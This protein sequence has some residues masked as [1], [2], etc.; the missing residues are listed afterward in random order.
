MICEESQSPKKCGG[1]LRRRHVFNSL[2]EAPG[3]DVFIWNQPMVA[4][5]WKC[6]T[7]ITVANCWFNTF[8]GLILRAMFIINN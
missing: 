7:A 6:Q 4:G 2:Q 1:A 3:G 8:V 5:K